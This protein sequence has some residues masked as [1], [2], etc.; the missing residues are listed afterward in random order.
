MA[1]N[2]TDRLRLAK[3]GALSFG[4]FGQGTSVPAPFLILKDSDSVTETWRFITD[5]WKL[6]PPKL[7]ISVTYD[8]EPFFM[9][10]RLLKSVL[11]DLVKA[12]AAK[13]VWITTGGT[14]YEVMAR[15]I[16]ENIHTCMQQ[17][18]DIYSKPVL[19][20]FANLNDITNRNEIS[21]S[22]VD[23]SDIDQQHY[24]LAM[25]RPIECQPLPETDHRYAFSN[26]PPEP[27]HTHF[28]LQD[29][30]NITDFRLKFERKK[31][32]AV[33]VVMEGGYQTLLTAHD[34]IKAD[35]PVLVFAGSGKAADFIAAA[36]D[37]REQP[38]ELN[39]PE[40][41]QAASLLGNDDMLIQTSIDKVKEMLQLDKQHLIS[42]YRISEDSLTH[43]IAEEIL[44]ALLKRYGMDKGI[45][46]K[47]AQDWKRCADLAVTWNCSAI[48]RRSIF[49]N[50]NYDHWRERKEEKEKEKN[51]SE[52]SLHGALFDVMVQNKQEFVYLFMERVNLKKFLDKSRLQ[53][54]YDKTLKSG[55]L[56]S[57]RETPRG[58][59]KILLSKYSTV[60][61]IQIPA[62]ETFLN[63]L[64][65]DLYHEV[66]LDQPYRELFVWAVFFSRMPLAMIFWKECP[67]QIGSALAASLM[68][69]KLSCEAKSAGKLH[70]SDELVANAGEFEKN[71]SGLL[72]WT[73]EIDQDKSHDLLTRPLQT[74]NQR[75][76]FEL[77]DNAGLM[78]FM[79]HDCCQTK[80]DKIWHGKL[81]TPTAMWKILFCLVCPLLIPWLIST[82]DQM[83]TKTLNNNDPTTNNGD[84]VVVRA[85]KKIRYF[86]TAPIVKFCCHSISYLVLL[87]LYSYFMTVELSPLEL[88]ITE[89][90]VWIW[91]VT[92]WLE[93]IR[94]MTNGL[95]SYIRD[96]WNIV[97]QGMYIILLV[98]VILRF[99]TTNDTDFVA[100]RY[101]YAVD[102]VIF[103]LR[104]LQLYYINKRLG[105]K[106]VVI[107]RMVV[108]LL[109]FALLCV[110]F[111][112]AYGVAAQS[113]L[114]P[115]S[116]DN[117]WD[118]LYRIFYHP[119]LSMFQEF[120]ALDELQGNVEDCNDTSSVYMNNR[121]IPRCPK[122]SWLVMTLFFIYILIASVMLVNLL[123]AIFSNEYNSVEQQGFKTWSFF[124]YSL[125]VEY[126]E[127]PLLAPPLILINL[128]WLCV[129]Y[130][131]KCKK[132]TEDTSNST[133][134]TDRT[135]ELTE[136]ERRGT[137]NYLYLKR[138]EEEKD[139]MDKKGDVM[140][141]RLNQLT[142][143]C[144]NISQKVQHLENHGE[145]STM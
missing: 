35:V 115:Q 42:V 95:K 78:D 141:H 67:D 140:L 101:V 31:A 82:D 6:P 99:T 54:L 16:G 47:K 133:T 15:Y 108:E 8:I 38:E 84:L 88:T 53:N 139:K 60:D 71:A 37:R 79:K 110:V 19:I 91:A 5:R 26:T 98:A 2:D 119:Y 45:K 40:M 21:N 9:N 114:Y 61:Q 80:L 117:W 50:A 96:R 123:I 107:F 27:H 76:V 36:Y 137:E 48:A 23:L 131:S 51:P 52:F 104:I 87:G 89:I 11:F 81:K 57:Q 43:N 112:F 59:L 105:P 55:N 109:Y 62:L 28:I 70:L 106:V 30:S 118:I 1:G 127:K 94:Q 86:Y 7:I 75:S 17:S 34:A 4:Q 66:K 39:G 116:E 24:E 124:R 41:M 100:A 69:K 90:L 102:L 143:M 12:A 130:F 56:S 92:L 65:N 18:E 144:R 145:R 132:C 29:G 68:L 126:Q 74:W 13:D 122:S 32:P 22:A 125:T 138:H 64:T 135:E 97:D 77:A 25:S 129:K 120:P 85:M 49:N 142:V 3:C 93:E 113:L 10:Q 134:L 33:V 121:D 72:E 58:L 103:Y 73:Y 83:D 63:S 128:L 20:G 14:M 46:N 111:M 44:Q 136:F